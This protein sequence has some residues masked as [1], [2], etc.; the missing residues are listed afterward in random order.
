MAGRRWNSG[1]AKG[2]DGVGVSWAREEG[3]DGW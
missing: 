3:E 2:G 1:V